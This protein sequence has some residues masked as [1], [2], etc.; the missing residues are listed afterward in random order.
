MGNLTEEGT[1]Q[2]G[3]L[4][5]ERVERFRNRRSKRTPAQM[6][7]LTKNHH[8]VSVGV[9]KGVKLV[10]G[11]VDRPHPGFGHLHFRTSSLE[12]VELVRVYSR[13]GVTLERGNEMAGGVG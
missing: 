4:D 11:P 13:K 8:Q 7:F 1:E 6:R 2:Q 3:S 10:S 12:L 9:V 5:S